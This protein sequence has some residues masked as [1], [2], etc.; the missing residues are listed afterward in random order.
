VDRSYGE[1][2]LCRRLV[3]SFHLSRSLPRSST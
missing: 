2:S 1:R 3:R